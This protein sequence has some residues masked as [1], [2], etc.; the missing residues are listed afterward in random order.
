MSNIK[1]FLDKIAYTSFNI[2]CLHFFSALFFEKNKKT[3]FIWKIIFF[4]SKVLKSSLSLLI[5]LMHPFWKVV[6]SFKKTK[7]IN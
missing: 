2:F 7:P 5:N 6:I 4:K 3:A 1:M